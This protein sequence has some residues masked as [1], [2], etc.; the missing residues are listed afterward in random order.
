MRNS[1]GGAG[2]G[3]AD[4]GA[5]LSSDWVSFVGCLSRDVRILPTGRCSRPG[6]SLVSTFWLE[7]EL[8]PDLAFWNPR[9]GL[10]PLNDALSPFPFALAGVKNLSKDFSQASMG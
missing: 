9:P 2:K 8:G 4:T 10:L 7:A 3:P 6:F 1:D 5:M